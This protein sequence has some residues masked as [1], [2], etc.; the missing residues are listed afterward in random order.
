MTDWYTRLCVKKGLPVPK[1]T[2]E[3]EV[4][5]F[6]S[7]RDPCDSHYDHDHHLRDCCC[8]SCKSHDHHWD[9]CDS[10]SESDCSS[11]S[12]HSEEEGKQGPP[13]PPGAK[14]DQGL[15]GVQG[16]QGLKGDQGPPGLK[17]DKGDQG[18]QGEQG[19]P[20]PKG[21][22]GPQGEQGEKGAEGRVSIKTYRTNSRQTIGLFEW[23][24]VVF[25]TVMPAVNEIPFKFKK[26]GITVKVISEAGWL[27]FPFVLESNTQ[28]T[29]SISIN[30]TNPES[31][32]EIIVFRSDN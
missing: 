19:S 2:F 20:G 7:H 28:T 16:P 29:L 13:G 30:K 11:E 6:D 21:D 22:Q 17:G 26:D 25:V 5:F 10:E 4:D 27:S 15:P 3:C 18:P 31:K 12:D 1:K 32:I 24:S 8:D 9:P 23:N 14:G